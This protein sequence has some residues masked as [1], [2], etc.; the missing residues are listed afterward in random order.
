MV[1]SADVLRERVILSERINL[2]MKMSRDKSPKSQIGLRARREKR[3]LLVV[4]L[5]DQ[6]ARLALALDNNQ[7]GIRRAKWEFV[8]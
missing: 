4:T 5:I 7:G 8:S 2:K 1:N 3:V 6:S